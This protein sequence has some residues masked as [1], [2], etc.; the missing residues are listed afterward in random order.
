MT[1][2]GLD[3]DLFLRKSNNPIIWLL[4]KMSAKQKGVL[5]AYKHMIINIKIRPKEIKKC[6]T[7]RLLAIISGIFCP[8]IGWEEPK[9]VCHTEGRAMDGVSIGT[10][11]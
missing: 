11:M 9:L 4:V 7:A 8:S 10:G 6:V 5:M 3:F 2:L 1:S